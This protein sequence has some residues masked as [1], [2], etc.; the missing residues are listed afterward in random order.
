LWK[1]ATYPRENARLAANLT[2]A[3]MVKTPRDLIELLAQLK[4]HEVTDAVG[5]VGPLGAWAAEIP[6]SA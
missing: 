2:A 1:A 4:R 3:E 6:S 5:V